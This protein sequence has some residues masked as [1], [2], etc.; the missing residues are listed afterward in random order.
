VCPRIL[1]S[2]QFA[3][4]IAL[5]CTYYGNAA[6]PK[7][8]AVLL[9]A[10]QCLHNDVNKYSVLFSSAFAFTQCELCTLVLTRHTICMQDSHNFTVYTVRTVRRKCAQYTLNALFV[11]T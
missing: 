1:L 6:P 9:V 4:F 3:H 10:A 8:V 7:L 5:K 11:R 2:T